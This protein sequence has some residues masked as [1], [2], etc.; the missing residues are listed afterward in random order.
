[1][2]EYT[3]RRNVNRGY[4]KLGVWQR[5]IDLYKLVW[6]ILNK[7]KID[8]KIR[9]QI[10]DAAQSVSSNIAEGYSRRS[11]NEYIQHVYFSLGSLSE[12]LS[13][14]V[15]LSAAD[16][17]TKEHFEEVD[18]LPTRL[19]TSSGTFSEASSKRGETKHG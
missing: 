8:L 16:Q 17:V 13:R 18:A 19:K 14:L 1:M 6:N 2:K 4:M 15:A 5:A 10:S 12:L 9:A 7:Q 11:V 3:K